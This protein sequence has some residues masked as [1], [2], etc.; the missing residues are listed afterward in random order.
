MSHYKKK[1]NIKNSN[2]CS[3]LIFELYLA[4]DYLLILMIKEKSIKEEEDWVILLDKLFEKTNE[5]L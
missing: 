4:Y 1:K 2:S 3:S 5:N